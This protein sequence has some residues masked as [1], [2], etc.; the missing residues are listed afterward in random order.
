MQK[1]YWWRVAVSIIGFILIISS[2]IFGHKILFSLCDVIGYKICINTTSQIIGKPLFFSSFFLI[3]ISPFLFLI[4]DKIFFKWLKFAL[5]WFVL[6]IIFITLAPVY[7]GGWMSF[8]PTK[9]SVSIWMGTLFVITSLAIIVRE[10]WMVK[11]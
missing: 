3:I 5:V 11:K 2:Y 9:E 4:S 7:T 8:G 1:T 6:T 10:K